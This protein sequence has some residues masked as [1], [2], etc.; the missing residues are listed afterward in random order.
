MS[1]T[2]NLTY[3]NWN[4]PIVGLGNVR[5]VISDRKFIKDKS[6]FMAELVTA[7][8]Y[9]AFRAQFYGRKYISQA[10]SY[11][12]GYNG[13]EKVAEISGD[14]NHNT[15]EFWEYDNRFGRRWNLD[16]IIIPSISDN[17]CF[18][19]NPILYIDSDGQIIVH[20]AKIKDASGKKVRIIFDG[21]VVTMMNKKLE[22]R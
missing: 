13:Q 20:Y 14:G 2:Q 12:F 10:G 21:G 8:D 6:I 3:C 15:A 11:L 7:T 16:P 5:A 22:R 9:Y 18:A 19:N 1:E 4:Y 17:A